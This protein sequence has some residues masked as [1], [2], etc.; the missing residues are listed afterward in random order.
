MRHL[1]IILVQRR[2]VARGAGFSFEISVMDKTEFNRKLLEWTETLTDMSRV[3]FVT[4]LRVPNNREFTQQEGRK[5]RTAER[6]C[7]TN[8]TRLFLTCFVVIFT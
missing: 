5:K 3:T 1:K 6:S 4:L 7:V 8:V 2:N